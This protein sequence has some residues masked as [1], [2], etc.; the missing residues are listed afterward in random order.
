MRKHSASVRSSSLCD[1]FGVLFSVQLVL[2]VAE[3]MVLGNTRIGNTKVST[4]DLRVP[5]GFRRVPQGSAG[6]RRVPQGSAGFRRVPQGSARVQWGSAG[7]E[8]RF[9]RVP[10]G[11]KKS[12][13]CGWG[14]LELIF[15]Y[16]NLFCWSVTH[17]PQI[18][19]LLVGLCGLWSL[20]RP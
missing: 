19:G 6:F 5:Q 20:D 8:A 4:G 7:S 17:P 15:A 16:L 13:S 2:G 1:C 9:R 18:H 11:S 14:S 3:K 12:T 10:Q